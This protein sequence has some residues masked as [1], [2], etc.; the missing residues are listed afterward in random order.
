MN[1]MMNDVQ[2]FGLEQNT[3]VKA[4][5]KSGGIE[6]DY[7]TQN[8]IKEIENDECCLSKEKPASKQPAHFPLKNETQ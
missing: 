3:K 6:N 4:K 5:E 8:L 2:K 7:E 1:S